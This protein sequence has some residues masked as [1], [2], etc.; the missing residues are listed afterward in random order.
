MRGSLVW[1]SVVVVALGFVASRV[2]TVTF[3]QAPAAAAEGAAVDPAADAA[4]RGLVIAKFNGGQ[5][6]VA[7]L[8]D[9]IKGQ[10]PFM[11]MR[12]LAPEALK[13]LFS[14]TLRFDLLA[15]EAERRGI[16]KRDDVNESIKQNMVQTLYTKEFDEKITPESMTA[17]DVQTYYESHPE[18]F[19]RPALRRASHIVVATREEAVALLTQVKKVDVAEFRRLAREKSIDQTN[20]ARGGDLRYFDAAGQARGEPGQK[21]PEAVVK[22]TFALKTVG[23]VSTQPIAIDGGFSVVKFTG[24]RPAESRTLAESEASI[25]ARLWRVKRQ[26]ALEHFVAELRTRL[27]PEVH[28]QLV[29]AITFADVSATSGI[30]P[31][32]PAGH[33]PPSAAIAAPESDEPEDQN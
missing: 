10:S 2:V 4:R 3:A 12:F 5:I 21:I 20:K 22:A 33:A 13:D 11:Q 6:T 32:F 23:D 1:S 15:G 17:A 25:R 31:G 14:R 30:A 9:D 24:E 7:T 19:N 28:P 16:D 26:E 8:E 29:D 27:K 18:E